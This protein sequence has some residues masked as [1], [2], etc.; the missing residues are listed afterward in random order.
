MTSQNRILLP[1][2]A[3]VCA[4][5]ALLWFLP[6]GPTLIAARFA[7]LV[8]VVHLMWR[9]HRLADWSAVE[10][11]RSTMFI[12]GSILVL[13]TA[14]N[15]R[16][17]DDF[18]RLNVHTAA[19]VGIVLGWLCMAAALIYRDRLVV[20]LQGDAQALPAPPPPN[21]L[22]SEEVKDDRP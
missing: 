20:K 9:Y 21:Y 10:I 19:E 18:T 22:P 7:A 6:Q 13:A 14:A 12:K 3:A 8:T 1:I 2:V 16:T 15:L 11:G 5:V 17:L 4:L